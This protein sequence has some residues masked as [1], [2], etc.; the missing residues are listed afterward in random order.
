MTSSFKSGS[1]EW[2]QHRKLG[3]KFSSG[4]DLYP[5]SLK[6]NSFPSYKN[7]SWKGWTGEALNFWTQQMRLLC[8]TE[9]KKV[10]WKSMWSMWA[11]FSLLLPPNSLNRGSQNAAVNADLSLRKLPITRVDLPQWSTNLQVDC[12][13]AEWSTSPHP[14]IE[15]FSTLVLQS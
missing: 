8:L 2:S 10:K 7:G 1:V 3:W 4:L 9:Y 5:R 6:V 14:C 13:E 15:S 12:D 11:V